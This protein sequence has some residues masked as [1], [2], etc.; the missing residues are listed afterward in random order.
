MTKPNRRASRLEGGEGRRRS[1]AGTRA[2]PRPRRTR[3]AFVPRAA[4]TARRPPTS[5][6]S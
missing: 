5:G 6:T 2:T 3:R 1:P 4:G